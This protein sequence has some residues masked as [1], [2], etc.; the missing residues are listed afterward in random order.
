MRL[1][2]GK[3][4]AVTTTAYLMTYNASKC[5][6]NCRFC[7]QART[8]QS[9]AELLSRIPWPSFRSSFAIDALENSKTKHEIRRVCI[10]A[11]N[12]NRVFSHLHEIVHAI[13]QRTRLPISVSCQPMN[14]NEIEMLQDAGV[15]R[16]GIPIDAATEEIF[17]RTKG[18]LAGGPYVWEK[19]FRL[20]DSAV[21]I[22]GR[23]KVTT[24]LIVGLGETEKDIVKI[25]QS[26]ADMGVLPSLFAFT[27]IEG[28]ALKEHPRPSMGSYRRV[29]LARYIIVKGLADLD[30]MNFDEHL[31][32][33][34]FGISQNR[35]EPL[36]LSGEPFLTSGCPHCNRPYYN[37]TPNGPIYNYPRRLLPFEIQTAQEEICST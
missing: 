6:A 20:L 36:L 33:S 31:R 10:Q 2:P 21:G 13:R 5:R 14:P 11:L 18:R 3:M 24:H 16:I 28:T 9:D 37:E 29:Q 34:S 27:P 35:L 7:S 15:E 25:V 19:Q 17:A 26:C 30:D 22:F 1:L 12:Y 8:S 23:E 4:S 32:V